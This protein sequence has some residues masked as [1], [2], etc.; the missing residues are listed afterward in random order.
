M[1]AAPPLPDTYA[2]LAKRLFG[3]R[4]HHAEA[5]AEHLATSGVERGLIGPREVERL[6]ERHILNCALLSD[7]IPSSARDVIDVGSGAGLPGL[8]LA[9]ARPDLRIT[10]VE[11]MLRRTVW[12][13]EVV[14]DLGLDVEVRRAR[15][16]TLHGELDA[17]IVTARAVAALDKLSKWCL[18]LVRDGGS[19]IALKGSSAAREVEDAQRVITACGGGAPQIVELGVGDVPNPTTV[20]VVQV[21]RQGLRSRPT[22]G[23]RRGR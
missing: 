19:L 11:T 17:D 5:Y 21:H 10:L 4:I 14:Q 13:T 6:W 7:A 16:E 9:I 3:E 1:A 23:E 22:R 15:A 12:L 2:P 20:V 18:P 8:V